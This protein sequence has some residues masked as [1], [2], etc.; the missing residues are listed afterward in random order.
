[1]KIKIR[2]KYQY[3]NKDEADIIKE[4]FEYTKKLEL[5]KAKK[6]LSTISIEDIIER[7]IDEDNLNDVLTDKTLKIYKK[8]IIICKEFHSNTMT[9][10]SDEIYDPMLNRY[11][12]YRDEPI[13]ENLK[14]SRRNVD[15]KHN[16][17]ELKGTLDKANVFHIS[18]KK[19]KLDRSL[20][21]FICKIF[22]TCD[23][24]YYHFIVTK[25]FDGASIVADV[26][27]DKLVL[28]L[29]RGEEDRKSVV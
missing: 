3:I 13:I 20:E 22:N 10:V 25:K 5:K 26:K 4:V 28:A 8:I 9:L 7:F 15:T 2:S 14:L 27:D 18:D 24:K 6:L 16:Y 19:V 1:M 23:N 17:P 21:E 12:L 11:K 29:T